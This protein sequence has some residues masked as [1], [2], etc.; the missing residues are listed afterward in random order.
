MRRA[1]IRHYERVGML[2]CEESFNYTLFNMYR[3]A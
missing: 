2:V 1:L 3:N